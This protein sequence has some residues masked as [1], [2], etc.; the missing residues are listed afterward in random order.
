MTVLYKYTRRASDICAVSRRCSVMTLYVVLAF[1]VCCVVPYKSGGGAGHDYG[2][3]H[4]EEFYLFF[5]KSR[6]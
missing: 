6:R 2:G 4:S 3:R 5:G 1:L